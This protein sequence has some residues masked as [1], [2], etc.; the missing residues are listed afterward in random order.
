MSTSKTFGAFF[1][2]SRKALGLTLSEFCRRNG[3]DKGNISRLERGLVPPPQAQELLESYARALKLERGTIAW[4]RFVELAAAEN[5]RIPADL[6]ENQQMIKKLPNLYRK[7]RAGGQGHTNW[8]R[9]LDLERWADSY[10]ARVTLPQLVR[11]LVRARVEPIRPIGFPAHEQ[12]QRPGWDGIAEAAAGDEFV[13]EGTS[14]WELGVDQ[15]PQKKAEEDFDKRTKNPLGLDREK[16]TIVFVTPRKWQK[17]EEW[18]R[19]KK[20]LGIWKEVRV[21]DSAT[22][23]EWLEQ[24]PAVDAWLARI[25]GKK[26][27]GVI[28]VDYHWSNL[29]AMTVPSLKPEAFLASRDEEVEKLKAWLD[30][31]PGAMVIEARSPGEAI[32]FVAAFSRDPSW[33]E[34]FGARALIVETRDAWRN[35]SAA[36]DA[37]LLLIAHPSLSIEPELVAEAVRQGHRVLVS[38]NQAPREPVSSLKLPRTY[39]H[40]LEKALNLSGL[41]EESSRRYARE[42]GGS[43]TVLKRLL[44]RVPTT[45]RPEWSGPLDASKLVPM[46]L[47]GS[48]DES[49][50]GDHSAIAKLSGGSLSRR[51]GGGPAM[52]VGPGFAARPRWFPL[53]SRFPR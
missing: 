28:T 44:G 34:W 52:A 35:V 50:E 22:V 47:A 36:A 6:I 8:V 23:E 38:S 5:G 40:D 27:S 53:E 1:R 45:T 48:W 9:A 13:P 32:D 46:L 30:G 20:E 15:N 51:R 4:D 21:Y 16:T 43:L 14:G 2:A 7:H 42:A 49:S 29:Q 25:L 17:K 10:D 11:K 24:A 12:V 37:G 3:F 31:P 41:D 39:R 26:P 18:R 33:T 19:A